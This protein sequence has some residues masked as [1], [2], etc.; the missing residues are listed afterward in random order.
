MS[1]DF[2]KKKCVLNKKH[3]VPLPLKH[4]VPLVNLISSVLHTIMWTK[5]YENPHCYLGE[6]IH[7]IMGCEYVIFF[8]T[9]VNMWYSLLLKLYAKNNC[10]VVLKRKSKNI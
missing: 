3:V 6:D 10:K 8:G 7:F 2:R 5:K 9:K 1:G 4:V